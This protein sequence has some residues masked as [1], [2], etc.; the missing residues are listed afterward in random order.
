MTCIG[1]FIL[2]ISKFRHRKWR[3]ISNICIYDYRL[4]I[5]IELSIFD[6]LP[7][8]FMNVNKKIHNEKIKSRTWFRWS[9]RREWKWVEFMAK[10]KVDRMLIVFCVLQHFY[11]S[12]IRQHSRKRKFFIIFMIRSRLL[13]RW[14]IFRLSKLWASN[15]CQKKKIELRQFYESARDFVVEI[16]ERKLSNQLAFLCVIKDN[17]NHSCQYVIERKRCKQQIT[18][19]SFLF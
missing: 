6:K 18:W 2:I 15:R 4:G 16:S 3:Q 12:H 19:N 7:F 8:L 5:W 1:I 9:R 17:V 11:A 10:I 14:W 13:S